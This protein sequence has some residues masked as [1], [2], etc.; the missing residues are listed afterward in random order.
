MSS[1]GKSKGIT[2]FFGKQKIFQNF[3]ISWKKCFSEIFR[4]LTIFDNYWTFW[5]FNWFFLDLFW[6]FGLFLDFVWIFW[7][8]LIF[9]FLKFFWDFLDF[10]GLLWFLSKLLRLLLKV[11][12]IAKNRPK[13]HYKLFFCLKGKISLDRS[14]CSGPYLLVLK[15]KEG[16]NPANRLSNCWMEYTQ[17]AAA[18]FHWQISQLINSTGQ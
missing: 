4:F 7:F 17:R 15:H 11:T 12:K 18:N 2:F 1:F 9:W 13:Q 10:F 8:F 16:V 3:Q 14:P 6:F 5:V